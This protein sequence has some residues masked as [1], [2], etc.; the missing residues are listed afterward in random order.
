MDTVIGAKGQGEKVLLTICFPKSEVML[1]YIRDAN[2]ARSVTDVFD[3]IKLSLGYNRFEEI[4]PLILT[5]NGSEFS[6]PSAI[7]TDD[8]G[9]LW[10]RIYY[11]EPY[12]SYQKGSIENGHRLIRAV[13][14]KGTSMGDL[15]QDDVYLMMSHINS[16]RRKSLGGQTPIEVFAKQ[17]GNKMLKLLGIHLINQNEITLTLKLL[18]H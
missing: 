3:S 2:T 16:Y 13:L 5:D 9:R 18:K 14:P 1:A 15:S 12:C 10:T 4:F 7:E 11:C 6:N 17:Y 8:D